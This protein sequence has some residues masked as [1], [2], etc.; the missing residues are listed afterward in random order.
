MAANPLGTSP[1]SEFAFPDESLCAIE[2]AEQ[3]EYPHWKMYFDGAVNV[4]G[5]GVG[6]VI[7]SPNGQQFPIA[8]KLNFQC[9]NNMA[10]Y[11]A[12]IA[13]LQAAVA[14]QIREL[15]VFGDSALII[16][17]TR[18]EWQT[19]DTKL[20]P[21]QKFLSQICKEFDNISFTHLTR[22][23]NM[24]ADALATLAVMIELN[25]GVHVQPIRV[26]SRDEAVYCAVVEEEKR[27][28]TM[29]L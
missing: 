16:Y 18:G 6:A 15:E 29:V 5:C 27:W 26:E 28:I 19:K 22:D 12:C 2:K 25:R 11:E 4:F 10:E 14:L 17:Q 20:I 23:K 24:F 7:M 13:G 9:T 8:V 1:S 21:Y 3:E